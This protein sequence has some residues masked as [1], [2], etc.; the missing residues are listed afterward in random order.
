VAAPKQILFPPYRLD[1]GNECVWLGKDAISLSRKAFGVLRYLLEHPARLVTKDEL[2]DSVWADTNVGEGVLKVAVAEIRKALNDGSRTPLY[3]ETAHRRGYRFI[4]EI[5]EPGRGVTARGGRTVERDSDLSRLEACLE[6]ALG[7]Q[8]QVV[9]ITGETGLGKTTLVEAFVER[10]AA[11]GE[12]WIAQGQCLEHFGEG[13]P[14]LP[15][16]EALSRLGRQAGRERLLDVLR[17]YA[18]TWLAQMPSLLSEADREWLRRQAPGT[19]KER[20]L[21]EITEAIEALTAE[22]SLVLILED[23]HWSDYATVDLIGYLALRRG[24][25]RLLVIGTY[26]PAQL[27][28][29]QHPLR[30]LKRELQV[31]NRCSEM[32]LEFL[33]EAAVAKYLNLRFPANELPGEL[34]ALIHQRT[35]GNPLFMVNAADYLVAQG[36]IVRQRGVDVGERWKLGVPLEELEIGIPDS[37]AQ[38][39]ERQFEQLSEEEQ[40]VLSVAA[41]AG[42][43]VST[44]TLSGAMEMGIREIA[45]HCHELVKR[46]QFLRPAAMIQLHDGSLLERYGFI[47]QFH[48]HAL[49]Q[50]MT[51]PRR[52]TLHRRLGEFQQTEY[53]AH[54]PEIAAELA[55]HFEQGLDYASAIRYRRLCSENASRIQAQREAVEHLG[56]ALKLA[57]HLSAKDRAELEGALLEERAAARRN[58]DDNDGAAEDLERAVRCASEVGRLD[59]KVRLLLQLTSVTFWTSHERSLAAADQSVELS[60]DLADPWLHLQARG[61]R[62]GR[63]IRLEG[64]RDDDFQDCVSALQ[65]AKQAGDKLF[66]GLHTM[67]CSFFQSYRAE[68]RE[69]CR[70]ADEG[71]ALGMETVDGF[72]YMSCQYFKAWALLYL[73][74]WGEALALT[75]DALQLAQKSGHVTAETV[76]RMID[77]RMHTWAGDFAAARQIAEQTLPIAKEGFPRSVTLITLGHA[78]LG[79]GEYDAAFEV[80]AEVERKSTEGP[81]RLDWIFQLPLHRGLAELHFARSDWRR[82][83]VEAERLC[84]LASLPGERTHLA[85]GNELL[86]RIAQ[87]QGLAVEAQT[88]IERAIAALENV[89]APLA[90]WRVF[91]SAANFAARQSHER[92]ASD[93]RNASA[94]ALGRIIESMDVNE[95]L[96]Q[97][98]LSSARFVPTRSHSA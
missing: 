25:A 20:M 93:Y 55:M 51:P 52:A 12:I 67:S 63:R 36:Q 61:Y 48:Q 27:V 68:Y 86:A 82:A 8:R 91:S 84:E 88:H 35:E 46:R 42:L 19:G 71:I 74:E 64:W 56:R 44:R 26:R 94:D 47:H 37:L 31:H 18:P 24:E 30:T 10:V 66:Q 34:A 59:W 2:L 79:L 75:R 73:G 16:L 98:L 58:M 50:K 13:E 43:E 78:Y 39:L 90:E 81:F 92:K 87:E 32:S 23:L 89:E 40:E 95:E 33:T 70:L 45:A 57:E 22:T 17:R 3:I 6:S 15:V 14:Y 54:L 83:T 80:F 97:R 65:A 77:A 53:A 29:K 62:A 7:G 5:Q 21:R 69:A 11:D 76:L 72:L 60:R 49:Y 1:P 9:F 28:V 38:M 41:V 4:G 85:L 96:R